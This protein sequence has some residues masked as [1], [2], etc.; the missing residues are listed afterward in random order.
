MQ[1][2]THG[3]SCEVHTH[4][5]IETLADNVNALYNNLLKTI[6]NL[7]QEIYK[8]EETEG[9]HITA[10]DTDAAVISAKLAEE[11]NL[12]IGSALILKSASDGSGEQA[13]VFV[14]GI[15]A[16]DSKMEYDD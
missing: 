7:E 12:G 5:E 1:G 13:K 14:A 2:L 9:R 8:A 3:I 11:N 15:Y 4:D 6:H 16:S 10:E